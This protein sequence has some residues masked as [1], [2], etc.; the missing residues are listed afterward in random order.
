MKKRSNLLYALIIL[1][2]FQFYLWDKVVDAYE[3]SS[4]KD[5]FSVHFLDI[6]QGDATLIQ[7]P[8]NKQIL[9]DGG[10]DYTVLNKELQNVMPKGDDNIEILILTHPDSDHLR[11]LVDLIDEYKTDLIIQNPSSKSSKIYK[12][13]LKK[14]KKQN[15]KVA[16][17]ISGELISYK[18]NDNQE[19]FTLSILGPPTPENSSD[20]NENSIITKLDFQNHSFIFTGDAGKETENLLSDIYSTTDLDI[21]VLKVGHHGSKHSTS[22]NFVAETSPEYS[23]ISCGENN[24]YGHP[25]DEVL[26]TIAES[27]IL[28]TDVNGTISFVLEDS[29]LEI[30]CSKTDC[31][32]L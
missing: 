21:D 7:T 8:D 15:I 3:T 19:I 25:N 1:I 30:M 16:S 5:N 13:W 24:S 12:E 27:E 10:P 17:G 4:T 6:G 11:G 29:K 9:I 20:A 32:D 18:N 22:A 2:L 23:I 31:T 26:E 28:R 14:I